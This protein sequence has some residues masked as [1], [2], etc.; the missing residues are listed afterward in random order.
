LK[1]WSIA[2]ALKQCSGS[3]AKAGGRPDDFKKKADE[4]KSIRDAECVNRV[5]NRSTLGV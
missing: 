2:S 3:L 4:E 5:W 1:G